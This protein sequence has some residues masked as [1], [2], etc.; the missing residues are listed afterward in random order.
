[1]AIRVFH[2][3]RDEDESGISGTGTVAEVFEA[4][5]G[6]CIVRWLSNMSSTNIYSNFKQ[7]DQIH[8]HGGKTRLVLVYDETP[9]EEPE[10]EI[11]SIRKKRSSKKTSS[12][13]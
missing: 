10:P 12:K 4:S 6:T 7:V 9:V 5:D 8:G 3:V 1:M 13:D 2:L 11:K